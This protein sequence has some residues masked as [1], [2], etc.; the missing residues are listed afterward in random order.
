MIIDAAIGRYGCR[1]CV[2]II[3]KCIIVS[4]LKKSKNLS[5]A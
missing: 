4:L 2:V 5:S 1:A 3:V